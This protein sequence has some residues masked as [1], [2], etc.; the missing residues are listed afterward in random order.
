[1]NSDEGSPG[2]FVVSATTDDGEA[3]KLDFEEEHLNSLSIQRLV[4]TMLGWPLSY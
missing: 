4:W 1:M 3:S 2:P